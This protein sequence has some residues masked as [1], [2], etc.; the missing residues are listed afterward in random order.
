MPE[1]VERINARGMSI[2][3]NWLD[4]VT[5]NLC[6]D[7]QEKSGRWKG[8]IRIFIDIAHDVCFPFAASAGTMTAK[9]FGFDITLAFVRPLNG[10]FVTN[11]LNVLYLHPGIAFVIPLNRQPPKLL[12]LGLSSEE[13]GLFSQTW[14]WPSDW[15]Q[16]KNAFRRRAPEQGET[17]DP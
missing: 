17:L 11:H 16:F 13:S 10:Q 9:F 6:P 15:T 8:F 2:S 14:T 7:A 5:P 3:P 1:V 4:A 12:C